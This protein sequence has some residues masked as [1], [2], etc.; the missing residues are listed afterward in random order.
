MDRVIDVLASEQVVA[1]A[2]SLVTLVCGGLWT[3]VKTSDWF[4]RIK[5]RRWARVI[6]AVEQG[7]VYAGQTYADAVKQAS[8]DGKLTHDEA[9]RALNTARDAAISFGRTR[10]VDVLREVGREYI[11]L[12]IEQALGTMK[13]DDSWAGWRSRR[14]AA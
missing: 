8:A 12:Y 6:V 10:G 7:V 11:D 3:L 9:R 2:I 1:A 4:A 14:N 5:A 13:G